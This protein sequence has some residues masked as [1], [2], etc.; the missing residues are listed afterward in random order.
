MDVIL[1][2]TKVL[3]NFLRLHLNFKEHKRVSRNFPNL[4]FNAHY[5]ASIIW[6]CYKESD[7][8]SF[9]KLSF[10]TWS[11]SF[12]VERTSVSF[13][14]TSEI[15]ETWEAWRWSRRFFVRLFFFRRHYG[16]LYLNFAAITAKGLKEIQAVKHGLLISTKC[17]KFSWL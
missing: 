15:L 8:I 14:R 10:Q 11:A 2:K 17:Y 4:D 1:R 9:V 5:I 6:I 3:F 13:L 16:K 12:L 7:I